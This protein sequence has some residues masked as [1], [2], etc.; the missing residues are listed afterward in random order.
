MQL[1]GS[2]VR[3]SR[4]PRLWLLWTLRGVGRSRRARKKRLR[5]LRWRSCSLPLAAASVGV[6]ASAPPLFQMASAATSR[7]SPAC[8][9]GK[10][11]ARRAK[12]KPALAAC[13]ALII[14]ACFV[15]CGGK[16]AEA[17]QP[18]SV[19]ASSAAPSP[20]VASTDRGAPR[21]IKVQL[22]IGRAPDLKVKGGAHVNAGDVLSDRA[23]DRARLTA[24]REQVA[25]ALKKILEVH[26]F[27]IP[28]LPAASFAEQL[29]AIERAQVSLTEAQRKVSIQRERM[30]SMTKLPAL[31]EAVKLHEQATLETLE[32]GV[33]AADADLK[34]ASAKLDTAK[35]DRLRLEQQN[36]LEI[37][38]QSV[39]EDERSQQARVE[40]AQLEAQLRDID[41]QL[42]RLATV[43]APFGGTI[44][45]ISWEGQQDAEI[46]VL[47]LIAVDGSDG[48]GSN[49]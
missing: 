26:H 46:T 16:S 4:A 47:V 42:A 24:Q 33:T 13:A 19:Q 5:L 37:S 25:L 32:R 10:L 40:R 38:R 8:V 21:N 15:G 48:E 20:E 6:V 1:K 9:F 49:E 7:V 27:E 44:K 11:L 28:A 3:G 17:T 34:L 23:A 12:T 29:A 41:N 36:S 14:A 22:T 31:P 35:S 45:R 43:R 39:G 2:I 30:E 18:F